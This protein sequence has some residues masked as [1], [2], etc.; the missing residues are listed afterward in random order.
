MVAAL[1]V[2]DRAT[3]EIADRDERRIDQTVKTRFPV[4]TPATDLL[5]FVSAEHGECRPDRNSPFGVSPERALDCTIPFKSFFCA[6]RHYWISVRLSA[7]GHAIDAMK[8]RENA[9]YWFGT[10]SASADARVVG[11]RA[12]FL[13]AASTLRC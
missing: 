13:F 4:G 9:I 10:W 11:Y 6:K 5:A 2:W 3:S 12:A 7:G 8:G 1:F